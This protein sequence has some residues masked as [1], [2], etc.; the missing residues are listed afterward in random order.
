MA[1]LPNDTGNL[2]VQEAASQKGGY[3]HGTIPGDL[4]YDSNTIFSG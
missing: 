1:F 2:S 4:P 3:P